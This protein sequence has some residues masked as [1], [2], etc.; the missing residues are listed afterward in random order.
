MNTKYKIRPIIALLYNL[1]YQYK[2][3]AEKC[4]PP[5]YRNP[6]SD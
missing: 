5:I 6:Q 3:G 4:S 1:M 2:K